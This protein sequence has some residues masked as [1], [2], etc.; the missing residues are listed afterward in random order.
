MLWMITKDF[1]GTNKIGACNDDLMSSIGTTRVPP[2]MRKSITADCNAEFRLFD[3]TGTLCYEGVC[4][5]YDADDPD[6][7][8]NPLDEFRVICSPPQREGCTR[9]E[10]RVRGASEWDV[11][12]S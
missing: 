2:Q 12:A 5:W 1:L 4:R 9:M 10:Y 11:I 6:E 8:T 7:M 3:A